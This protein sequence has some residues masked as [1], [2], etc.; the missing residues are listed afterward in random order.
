MPRAATPP[1]PRLA[2]YVRL[3][4]KAGREEAVADFLAGAL[5]LVEGEPATL[6]WYALRLEPGV[7]AIYDTFSDEHGREAHLAGQV[8]AA[9]M[10]RAGD[11]LASP[12]EIRKIE[13]IAAK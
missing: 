4:A 8:A 1:K 7:F 6:T 13:V 3:E 9:L 10:S 12:P 2:L 5:P 11:L